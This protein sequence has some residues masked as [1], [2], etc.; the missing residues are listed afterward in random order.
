M[1]KRKKALIL[2]ANGFEEIEAVCPIDIL[3][4]ADISVTISSCEKELTVKGR[5]NISLLADCMLEEINQQT[6]DLL[7]LPGGPAVFELRKKQSVLKIIQNHNRGNKWI[8]AICAAPLLLKD[9]NILGSL[10]HTAHSSVANELPMLI[11]GK[12]IVIDRNLVTSPGAG[13]GIQFGLAL[14]ETLL[15]SDFA[16][17]IAD[18][19]H[20]P[21]TPLIK[22]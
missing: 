17:S 14:I 7:L 8:C 15:N 2:L 9:A 20:A 6:F 18:S 16:K 21:F 10:K 11:K 19:I 1:E 5:S 12:D 3:R 22:N 13:T 4:R